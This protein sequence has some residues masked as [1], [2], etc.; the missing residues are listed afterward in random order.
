MANLARILTIDPVYATQAAK[1]S[2]SDANA[3]EVRQLDTAVVA[4]HHV[5]DVSL[6][7]DKRTDLAACL[8]RQLAQLPREFR[9]NDLVA[10]YTASVQLFDAPQLIW[11]QPLSVA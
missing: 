5:L 11:F 2:R 7:I 1:P 8:V 10:R 4:D 3:F 6:T 9:C